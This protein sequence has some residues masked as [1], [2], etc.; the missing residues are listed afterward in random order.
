MVRLE[1]D[2]APP[3]AG[4]EYL[5]LSPASAAGGGLSPPGCYPPGT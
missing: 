3:A 5:N 1:L 4:L 2:F